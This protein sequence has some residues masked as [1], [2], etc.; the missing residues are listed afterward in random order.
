MKCAIIY[1][2]GEAQKV[3]K[4]E[5]INL[6]SI[7][8]KEILIKQYASSINPI[9]FRMRQGYGRVLLSKKRGFSLPLI[10]GRDV[11]GVV[12]QVGTGIKNLKVGD[13]V[14]GCNAPKAQGAY[15]EFVIAREADVTLKPTSLSFLEGASF[16]YVACTVWDA[17]VNKAGLGPENTKGKRIFIQGGAG[18]IGSFAIQL[19]K[20]WGGYVAT[21]CRKHQIEK[22]SALGADLIIDYENDDYTARLSGFD[23]ALE[24]VGG[25][26]ENKTLSILRHDGYGSFVTLI[27]PL[28]INFDTYGLI[29]GGFTNLCEYLNKR[30]YA[31][32]LN[33]KN[34]YWST[35]KPSKDAL[36]VVSEL[37]KENLLHSFIDK[38]FDLTEIKL[39]H[40]Y[41]EQGNSKGKVVIRIN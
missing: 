23:V 25:V 5:N 34:Y 2:Y 35:F 18:G 41:C 6:P 30:S 7:G 3:F 14:Y 20:A 40:E 1:E 27:H 9:D 22:L 32:T 39:A 29:K 37:I 31:R 4:I 8:K 19:V 16:P 24:T 36:I 21:T 33:V 10:L 13:A 12:V 11:S 15:A 26:F 38:E 28:L 17:L